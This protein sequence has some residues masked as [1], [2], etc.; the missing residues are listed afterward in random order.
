LLRD[1]LIAQA[2]HLVANSVAVADW[3]GH[4]GTLIRPNSVAPALFDLPFAPAA[5]LR[6]G[7]VGSLTHDKGLHDVLALARAVP[8]LPVAFVLVGPDSPALQDAGPLPA[9]VTHA[10]YAEGAE[11]AMA[12]VDVVLSLSKVAESYGR[13]VIEAMAA[14]RSMTAARRPRWCAM[15][16]GRVRPQDMSPP[17]MILA[18]LSPC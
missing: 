18:R 11:A 10:G 12:Q 16:R 3:L 1:T 6:V 9:N 2:D 5:P 8:H 14:A 7:L 17:Q 4:P 15:Q 13:T